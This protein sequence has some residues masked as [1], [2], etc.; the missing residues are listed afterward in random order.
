MSRT[1]TIRVMAAGCSLLLLA[2]VAATSS[3]TTAS[4]PHEPLITRTPSITPTRTPTGVIGWRSL[5][6]Q[7]SNFAATPQPI[8]GASVDIK[9]T[10]YHTASTW[11]TVTTDLSG[12][13]SFE[14]IYLY[15]T[16]GVKVRVEAA[17]YTPQEERR[18]AIELH[19][20]PVIDFKLLWSNAFYLAVILK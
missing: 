1:N 17:G 13:Y 20:K 19:S 8:S 10:S 9:H 5:H 14:P 15:D 7:V 4:P 12:V 2:L 6:G 3:I 11:I 18:S 16:D